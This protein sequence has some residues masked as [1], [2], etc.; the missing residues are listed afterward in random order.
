M[1]DRRP[2][3]PPLVATLLGTLLAATGLAVAFLL[4]P[5]LGTDLSAQVARANFFARHGFAPLDFGWYGG[6]SPYGYSLLTPPLMSWL[7]DDSLG[8]RVAGA[9]ALVGSAVAL[10]LILVRTGARRP[11]LGGL[12][13]A[14]CVAGNLA[15]GR[16]TYAIGVAFGLLAL[17]A[18]TAVRPVLRLPAAGLAAGLA[19]AASPVAGVFVGLAGVALAIAAVRPGPDPPSARPGRDP[20]VGA[21]RPGPDPAVGAARPG[22]DPPSARPGPDPAVGAARPGPDPA[23]GAARPGPDPPSDR[24]ARDPAVGAVRPGPDPAAGTGPVGGRRFGRPRRAVVD[25]AVLALA[26]AVPVAGMA[27]LFGAGGWMNIDLLDALR[28]AGA[29]VVVAALVPQRALRIGAGLAAA[30]VLVA[31]AVRTPVGLNATRLAAMFALPVL[32]AYGT[33]PAVLARRWHRRGTAVALA[34]TVA[35]VALWQPPVSRVDLRAAGDLTASRSYFQPLLA[36]LARRPPGRIEVVP[37]ANYWEAAYVPEVAP[38]ARGWLRQADQAYNRLFLDGSVDPESYAR[39]LRENGVAYVAVAG[40][41]PSWVGRREAELIRAGLPYLTRIWQHPDW[42]LYAVVA[43]SSIVDLLEPGDDPADGLPDDSDG[44]PDGGGGPPDGAGVAGAELVGAT[45]AA[46][47][48]DLAAPGETL[49]RVR[50][51]RWL[52]LEGPLGPV[53]PIGVAGTGTVLRVPQAGRYRIT[54]SLTAAGPH[55]G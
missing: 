3:A 45:P 4:A 40:A 50:W 5:P 51:S 30:G 52:R 27:L 6:V 31:F 25:G 20:A 38:L 39:W 8:P 53:G 11:V 54:G 9:A 48:V 13:G 16:I 32:V 28:A 15:S 21:A 43:P 33:V 26:A 42:T 14:F 10:A 23:V 2:P 47:T 37:T 1:P 36:E 12:V 18:L 22:P 41:E 55:C 46:V 17:L 19:A 7:G 24:P 44:P 29:S 49:L 34:G 35:L